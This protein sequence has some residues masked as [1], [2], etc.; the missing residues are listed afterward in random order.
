MNQSNMCR[1][2]V[3]GCFMRISSYV[4]QIAFGRFTRKMSERAAFM[5]MM[6]AQVFWSRAFVAFRVLHLLSEV[7]MEKSGTA[8]TSNGN[9][10]KLAG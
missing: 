6:S 2:T 3:F 5:A 1:K 9:R 4:S 8:S 10:K 7:Q